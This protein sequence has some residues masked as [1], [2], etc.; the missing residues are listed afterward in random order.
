[1]KPTC[2]M[3]TLGQTDIPNAKCHFLAETNSKLSCV[4]SPE[5][6]ILGLS[7]SRK[8]LTTKI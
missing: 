7:L 6:P 8:E 5:S 4:L 3:W 1:M 2:S